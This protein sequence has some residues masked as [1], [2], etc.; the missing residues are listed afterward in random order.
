MTD[1]RYASRKFIGY[2]FLLVVAAG[3][4]ALERCSF[5]E[6]AQAV[7]MLSVLYFGANVA[8]KVISPAAVT[9]ELSSAIAR[10]LE[11]STALVHQS[12]AQTKTMAELVEST[13]AAVNFSGAGK[14]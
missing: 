12:A 10:Q 2:A 13:M 8:Q 7:Q 5:V 6:W 14:L 1:T 3:A 9:P 11:A 4:L